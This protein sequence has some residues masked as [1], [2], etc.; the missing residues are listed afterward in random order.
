MEYIET[1]DGYSI[2]EEYNASISRKVTLIIALAVSVFILMCFASTIGTGMVDTWDVPSIIW[3]HILG[4]TY[5]YNS[6]EWW[7]DY[8]VWEVRMPRAIMAIVGGASLAL[9]GAAVQSLMGNPLADPYTMG[10]AS[11]AV[12]GASVAI[13]CGFSFGSA[14]GTYGIAV[15]AFVFGLIP[16]AVVLGLSKLIT[17]NPVTLILVGVA[18]SQFFGS[19]TNLIMVGTDEESLQGAYLWQIGSLDGAVWSEIPLML[20][21]VIVSGVALYVVSWKFNVISLGDES[22]KTLGVD[23]DRF[24]LIVL[25]LMALLTMSVVAFTG[26]IGF[27]GIIAPHIIRFLIGS[28]NKF[29]LP[30][31]VLMGALL[32]LSADCIS[33]GIVSY[34]IPVGAIMSLIGGP[35]FIYLVVK[36]NSIFKGAW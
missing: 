15:N 33:R 2:V 19:I 32:L 3:N 25:T 1:D 18:I 35:I 34:S 9:C 4:A 10:I 28:D 36:K 17:L 30:A 24:R 26:I 7:A 5:E 27:V 8:L 16:V 13:I 12:F 29:V 23:A 22:A 14:I 20:S 11:G 6:P 31:S 21:L